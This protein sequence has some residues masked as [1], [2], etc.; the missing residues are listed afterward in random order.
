MLVLP[1]PAQLRL[2]W[3]CRPRHGGAV[4]A[5][6]SPQLSPK[7]PPSSPL[8]VSSPPVPSPQPPSS[9]CVPLSNVEPE[10]SPPQPLAYSPTLSAHTRALE[11]AI[12]CLRMEN[13]SRRRK[14]PKPLP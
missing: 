3:H 5:P 11:S 7:Q 12:P 13:T 8:P 1:P 2:T 9:P 10:S 14:W 6:P 4:S